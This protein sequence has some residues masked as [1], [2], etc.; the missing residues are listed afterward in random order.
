MIFFGNDRTNKLYRGLFAHK[1]IVLSCQYPY[2]IDVEQYRVPCVNIHYGVLP[3]FR[4]VAPIY[5]QLMKGDTVGVTLHYMD[6]GFDT[7]DIIEVF[8]FPT[9]GLTA[10]EAYDRCEEVGLQ[11]IHK[12]IDGIILGTAPRIKQG[13]GTYYKAGVDFEKERRINGIFFDP[14]T[15]KRIFATHFKGK[16]FPVINIG[17]T[18]FEL[19]KA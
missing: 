6:S 11:L 12:H 5:H 16:Q 13:E 19:V 2:K 8:S 15:I 10:D 1:D 4:G 14:Q 3:Y 17:G 9:F 7:G 18:D